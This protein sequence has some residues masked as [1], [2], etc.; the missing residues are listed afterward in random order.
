MAVL[1][2]FAPVGVS[3]VGAPAAA[4]AGAVTT[5]VAILATLAGCGLAVFSG[6]TGKAAST[7]FAAAIIACHNNCPF[8]TL[9]LL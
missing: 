3:E 5:T 9:T 4:V 1:A 7:V 2:T 8:V 6:H